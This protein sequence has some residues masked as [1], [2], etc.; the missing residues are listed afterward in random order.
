MYKHGGFNFSATRWSCRESQSVFGLGAALYLQKSLCH[1][2]NSFRSPR[3]VAH[4]PW[5]LVPRP[6]MLGDPKA[7]P[8]ELRMTPA[9]PL[10]EDSRAT[11]SRSHTRTSVQQHS[12]PTVIRSARTASQVASKCCTRTSTVKRRACASRVCVCQ[13]ASACDHSQSAVQTQSTLLK[14]GLDQTPV[15]KCCAQFRVTKRAVN[16]AGREA[17]I[18]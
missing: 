14:N 12:I 7:R 4:H 6:P 10:D 15:R 16:T 1:F 8:T 2:C 17:K 5:T 3:K 9:A 13:R 18:F 11:R